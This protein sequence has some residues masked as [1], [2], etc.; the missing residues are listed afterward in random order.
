MLL[1]TFCFWIQVIYFSSL[2][3]TEFVIANDASVN[4]TWKCKYLFEIPIILQIRLLFKIFNQF[5]FITLTM[6]IS[7]DLNCCFI[8]TL[9]SF[10]FNN[11]HPKV[12]IQDKFS[13]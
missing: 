7:I 4:I 1:I 12:R 11:N 5:T 6:M 2:Y 3:F 13:S 8:D 9:N 10:N